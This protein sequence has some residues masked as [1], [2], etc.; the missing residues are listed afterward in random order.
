MDEL[1]K[2]QHARPHSDTESHAC[3]TANDHFGTVHHVC[4]RTDTDSTAIWASP[5]PIALIG[6][7]L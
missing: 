2:R 1:V 5:S 6:C 7:P 4:W 3:N